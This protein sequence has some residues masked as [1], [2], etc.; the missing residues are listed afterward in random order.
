MRE[1]P[2]YLDLADALIVHEYF[3]LGLP[4]SQQ[5]ATVLCG[6]MGGDKH[7]HA[8]YDRPCHELYDGEKPLLMGHHNY[9]NTD[10]PFLYQ[11][12]VFGLNTDC[13]TG[14]ALTE[15]LLPSFHFWLRAMSRVL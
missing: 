10:Q 2:L 15:L 1:L 4:L 13:V 11:D 6:T 5:R 7:L 9:S 12:R 8:Q 14:R 3:E